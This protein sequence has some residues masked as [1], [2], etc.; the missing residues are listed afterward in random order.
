[1]ASIICIDAEKVN[2]ISQDTY[3]HDL[4]YKNQNSTAKIAFLKEKQLRKF[5]EL[6][7]ENSENLHSGDDPEKFIDY[8]IKNKDQHIWGCDFKNKLDIMSCTINQDLAGFVCFLKQSKNCNFNLNNQSD[9]AKVGYIALLCVKKNYRQQKIGSL[10]IS[11][12]LEELFLRED[13][14]HVTILTKLD[15][16][17][18]QNL[19]AK[20]GFEKVKEDKV[21]NIALYKKSG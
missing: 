20:I 8:L 11:S 4:I 7:L 18:A 10:L 17:P 19:F 16:L 21:K 2:I 5:A 14:R 15:N 1:M 9:R 13:V 3:I 6:F 12:A